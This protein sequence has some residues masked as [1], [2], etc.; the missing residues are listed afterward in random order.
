LLGTQGPSLSRRLRKYGHLILAQHGSGDFMVFHRDEA[1]R[2]Y[3][4]CRKTPPPIPTSKE[5]V[6]KAFEKLIEEV[7]RIES[8]MGLDAFEILG[9][10]VATNFRH[11][12]SLEF[13]RIL[14]WDDSDGE[15]DVEGRSGNWGSR[16][17]MWWGKRSGRSGD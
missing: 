7:S 16:L 5:V 15:D 1:L 8:G 6:L 17:K 9:S 3:R 14:D 13:A 2:L 12:R 4:T 11:L 10:D